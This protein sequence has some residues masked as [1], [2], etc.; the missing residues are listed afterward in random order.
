[1]WCEEPR[2]AQLI[3]NLPWERY[4]ISGKTERPLVTPLLTVSSGRYRAGQRSH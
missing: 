1:V 2:G 3:A 4:E